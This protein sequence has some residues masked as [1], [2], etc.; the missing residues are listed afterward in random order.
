MS[1]SSFLR[2]FPLRSPPADSHWEAPLQPTSSSESRSRY[3]LLH[4]QQL[5]LFHPIGAYSLQ[6][7]AYSSSLTQEWLFFQLWLLTTLYQLAYHNIPSRY[8]MFIR[9]STGASTHLGPSTSILTHK[10]TKSYDTSVRVSVTQTFIYS[11]V[12]LSQ[13]LF[14]S[15]APVYTPATRVFEIKGRLRALENISMW[16]W[17]GMGSG[18]TPQS[19]LYS[20]TYASK[21]GGNGCLLCIGDYLLQALQKVSFSHLSWEDNSQNSWQLSSQNAWTFAAHLSV[22]AAV[23]LIAWNTWSMIGCDNIGVI[24]STT[25][26]HLWL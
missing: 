23:S 14:V 21:Y 13:V 18:P 17:W 7:T 9:N 25:I 4:L 24:F 12:I 8:P 22:N 26:C 10:K 16:W 5:W 15:A 6:L 1:T 2:T 11:T 19:I 20:F 3:H